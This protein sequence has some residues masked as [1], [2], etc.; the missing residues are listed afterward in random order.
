MN[1]QIIQKAILICADILAVLVAFLLSLFITF[2][3]HNFPTQ[4]LANVRGFLNPGVSKFLGLIV[5]AIF[6]YLEHYVKRRP[7]WEEFLQVVKVVSFVLLI[8]LGVVLILGKGSYKVLVVGFWLLLIFTIPLSRIVM[9]KIM[10]KFDYWKRDLFII[11]YGDS[12]IEAYKLFARNSWMGYRL[13]GFVDVFNNKSLN[14]GHLPASLINEESLLLYIKENSNSDVIVALSN[15][16]LNQK[17]WLIN[18]LQHECTSLLVLPDVTGLAFYGAEVEH[19]FGNEQLI[20]RMSTNLSKRFNRA[21]KRVFDIVLGIIILILVS[22]LLITIAI[23]IRVTTKNNVFFL[24][25]RVGKNGEIFPCVKFQ[26]MYPNSKE[27]LESLLKSDELIRAE[28]ESCFKLK[29]DPRVTPVGKFLRS[30]SLDEL[31][32]IFNVLIGQMSLVGPRPIILQEVERYK[33]GYY[34]YKMVLPGITGLWQVSG[35][36]DVD[37]DNRVRLDEFYVRNW[38]LWYDIVILFKTFGVVLKR[39]GAY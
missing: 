29:D 23:I 21:L 31:P 1:K 9:K 39:T 24:H 26:T 7:F 13:L 22:P 6:W 18:Y 36:S 30:T 35:R 37:Y 2:E 12:A 27:I 15:E 32:Q 25:N 19:F 14:Y 10:N 34:Y 38:S 28:W 8:N 33:E 5:I 11:G 16:E 17:I 3:Y 4:S 20:L